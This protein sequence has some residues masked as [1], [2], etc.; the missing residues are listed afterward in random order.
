MTFR[1]RTLVSKFGQFVNLFLCTSNP[2]Q[3]WYLV[4]PLHRFCK[5]GT[6]ISDMTNYTLNG[7][8]RT[9]ILIQSWYELNLIPDKAMPYSEITNAAAKIKITQPCDVTFHM[10]P[11]FGDFPSLRFCAYESEPVRAHQI[12]DSSHPL[13]AHPHSCVLCSFADSKCLLHRYRH[14][15]HL[16]PAINIPLVVTSTRDPMEQSPSS[17]VR[18]RSS[19]QIVYLWNWEVKGKKV[20]W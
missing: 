11:S 10:T 9:H 13:E 5:V 4:L 12:R 17:G 3:R 16:P 19:A 8:Y 6:G 7:F 18:S 14:L 2:T 1:S 15:V 20:K